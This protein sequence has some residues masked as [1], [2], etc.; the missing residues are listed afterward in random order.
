MD[1]YRKEVEGAEF[2][3]GKFGSLCLGSFL[4]KIEYGSSVCDENGQTWEAET[5][6]ALYRCA[7]SV[8]GRGLPTH[9]A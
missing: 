4:P 7:H 9:E 5:L 3:A 2:I 1:L 6:E 8:F